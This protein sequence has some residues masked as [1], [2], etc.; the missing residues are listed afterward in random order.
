MNQRENEKSIISQSHAVQI[1]SFYIN[2]NVGKV[3]FAVKSWNFVRQYYF[4]LIPPDGILVLFL[5]QSVW[6]CGKHNDASFFYFL[7]CYE[8]NN[9]YYFYMLLTVIVVAITTSVLLSEITVYNF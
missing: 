2:T 8:E 6:Y 4:V 1:I 5:M 7:K 3:N 9:I